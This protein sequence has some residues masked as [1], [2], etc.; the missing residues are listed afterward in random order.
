MACPGLVGGDAGQQPGGDQPQGVVRIGDEPGVPVD[1]RGQSGPYRVGAPCQF[2]RDPPRFVGEAQQQRVDGVGA[3]QPGACG[4]A[5]AGAAARQDLVRQRPPGGPVRVPPPV[6]LVESRAA[7][8]FGEQGQQLVP[9]E[10]G[11]YRAGLGVAVRDRLGQ[12]PDA[13]G[14]EGDPVVGHLQP[15]AQP[16]DQPCDGPGVRWFGEFRAQGD[17]LLVLLGAA[18]RRV[19][20]LAQPLDQFGPSAPPG[21]QPRGGP[22]VDVQEAGQLLGAGDLPAHE[23]EGEQRAP[24]R[25]VA[26][27]GAGGAGCDRRGL[28]RSQAATCSP[29]QRCSGARVSRP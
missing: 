26:Q 21:Q 6:D 29:P 4:A 8:T 11:Q 16:V 19:D 14:V 1:G 5:V 27:C 3:A 18:A 13:Q 22:A 25:E 23:G 28:P 2:R 24:W 15:R 17:E 20:E 7:R 10:I 12:L 9:E